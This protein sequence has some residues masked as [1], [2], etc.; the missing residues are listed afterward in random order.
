M[1]WKWA[2][3]LPECHIMDTKRLKPFCF[4]VMTQKLF[5]GYGLSRQYT[6]RP[7]GGA[8][9]MRVTLTVCLHGLVCFNLTSDEKQIGNLQFL[10]VIQ[11]Q[12]NLNRKDNFWVKSV[13][14]LEVNSLPTFTSMMGFYVQ[15]IE[16]IKHL[17]TSRRSLR[18]FV[19]LQ[20]SQCFPVSG[21][22]KCVVEPLLNLKVQS[23]NPVVCLL[24]DR[25]M[26]SDWSRQP[27]QDLLL[28]ATAK[29]TLRCCWR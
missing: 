24:T 12:T 20:H 19:I 21:A 13:I 25:W 7:A 2:L 18:P 11:V 23:E 3:L 28:K 1:V 9:F 17:I 15:R 6:I 22:A 29:R 4:T 10:P 26:T 27:C 16:Y 5:Y 14:C 8:F